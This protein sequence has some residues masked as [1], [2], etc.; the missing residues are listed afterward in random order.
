MRNGRNTSAGATVITALEVLTLVVLLCLLGWG[1]DWGGR[2]AAQSVIARSVQRAEHLSERPSV[3]LRGTFL[4]PQVVTGRYSEVD[5]TARGV[6]RKELRLASVTARLSGVRVALHD[7]VTDRI[8]T[9]FV[10]H[11]RET[12]AVAIAFHEPIPYQAQLFAEIDH[13]IGWYAQASWQENGIGRIDVT[14][15]DNRGLPDR[16]MGD[17]YA[18]ETHFWSGGL[19]TGYGE[20]T[21]LMQGMNGYTSVEPFEDFEVETDFK[22][23]YT[24][25]GWERGEWRLAGRAD[26]FQTR[27]RTPFGPNS[28]SEDGHAF[29]LAATWLPEEWLRLTGEFLSVDSTRAQ[30]A[31]LGISPHQIDNQF[32]FAA[33]FYL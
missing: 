26:V 33:R 9:I 17:Q 28:E 25:I 7:V 1:L 10:E 3:H 21:L 11:S 22:A 4:L 20:F 13:R 15:Y 19:R 27:T 23:A 8:S 30:R 31:I 2:I 18:W 6:R 29:T 16:E 14:R 12:D 32:Q 5:I 24:L